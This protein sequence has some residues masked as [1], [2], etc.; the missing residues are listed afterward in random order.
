MEVYR[1]NARMSVDAPLKLRAGVAANVAGRCSAG[2]FQQIP[3]YSVNAVA[4]ALPPEEIR[5]RRQLQAL[6]EVLVR[7]KDADP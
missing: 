4:D 1:T 7:P 2:G 6:R 5:V 3:W